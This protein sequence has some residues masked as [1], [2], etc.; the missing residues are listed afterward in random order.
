MALARLGGGLHWCPQALADFSPGLGPVTSAPMSRLRL[1]HIAY[2]GFQPESSLAPFWR[3]G[4][5]LEGSRESL[6]G[7]NGSQDV[8]AKNVKLVGRSG[9]EAGSKCGLGW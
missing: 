6:A 4:R 5:I 3:L 1:V 2:R 9:L 7:G 8:R